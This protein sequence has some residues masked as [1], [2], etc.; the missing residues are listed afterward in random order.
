M[1]WLFLLFGLLGQALSPVPHFSDPIVVKFVA[2]P[3]PR[4]AK[5]QRIMGKTVSEI[6]VG[7]DGSVR[8]VQRVRAHSVFANPVRD[9][10]KQWRFRLGN[11][12]YELE[13]TVSFEFDDACEGSDKHPITA[14]SR[15][16]AEFLHL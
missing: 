13:M 10:L 2:P 3:Y 16:S 11:Q 5:D 8:D 7:L 9:A 12:E 1:V 4:A 6:S 15:V 14:E